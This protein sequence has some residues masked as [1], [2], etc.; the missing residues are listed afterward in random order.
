MLSSTCSWAPRVTSVVLTA[1]AFPPCLSSI[2]SYAAYYSAQ[3]TVCQPGVLLPG[4]GLRSGPTRA[5]KDLIDATH[6]LVGQLDL[7]S[8]QGAV[9]L[10]RVT[11]TD[12]RG[13][14]HRVLQQPRQGDVR[15]TLADVG[16]QLLPRLE[17]VPV[18]LDPLAEVLVAASALGRLLES[19]GQQATGQRA[20]RDDA[21]PVALTGGKYLELD[22][23][24][25][26]V[27]EA[28]L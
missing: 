22:R 6:D 10:L 19:A 15:G 25:V 3:R 11:G 24:G 2:S 23:T 14:H 13:G 20:P 28:L 27:V 18:A 4:V 26:E 5:R 17:L 1:I 12:D 16:A 8:P 7:Q 21:Q 9:E